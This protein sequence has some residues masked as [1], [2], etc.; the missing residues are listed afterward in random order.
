[1]S[2]TKATGKGKWQKTSK[3]NRHK[4]IH[5]PGV[6]DWG[7]VKSEMKAADI[8]L[9]GAGA[10]EAPECYKKLDEVLEYQG[11]TIKVLHTLRP[12]GV[13]M[14]SDDVVDPFKEG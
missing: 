2:R 4:V 14:A 10:D 9:V 12:I 5:T 3:G 8:V 13:A 11:D 1:L 6:V 7:K